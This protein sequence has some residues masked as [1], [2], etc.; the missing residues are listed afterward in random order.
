MSACL[1]P[2]FVGTA[3]VIYENAS[4][5]FEIESICYLINLS[6]GAHIFI[7]KIS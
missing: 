2:L 4:G 1:S 3:D 6:L 5:E 7:L